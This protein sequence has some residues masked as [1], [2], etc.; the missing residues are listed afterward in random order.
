MNWHILRTF[1]Y[2]MHLRKLSCEFYEFDTNFTSILGKTCV[3]Q[4]LSDVSYQNPNYRVK[5]CVSLIGDR[6]DRTR[7]IG[8][9]IKHSFEVD[10]SVLL[11]KE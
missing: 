3:F 11:L 8:G 5:L 9:S 7:P 4:T 6:C 10:T 2:F 1:G